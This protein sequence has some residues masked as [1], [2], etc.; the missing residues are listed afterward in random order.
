M[1]KSNFFY[2]L[3][4]FWWM[5]LISGLIFIGFGAWCLCDP[6]ASLPIL[7]Y[8]FAGFIGVIGI[9]NLFYGLSNANANNG[10]GWAMAAGIVEILFSILLFFIPTAILTWVFCYGIGIYIIFMSIYAFC[11]S[12][13]MS[14]YSSIWFWIFMLFL[15]VALVFA[16]IFIL[17]PVGTTMMGWLYIGISF[18]CYGIYRIMFAC[19]IK[20]INNDFK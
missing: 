18:V 13:M 12:F 8:I 20:K 1:E 2:G 3:T 6:S 16:L 4:R 9:F 14:K 15:L 10:Y 5:P 11:E 19:K 7:A 17:G